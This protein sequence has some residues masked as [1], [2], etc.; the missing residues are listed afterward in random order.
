MGHHIYIYVDIDSICINMHQWIEQ[1]ITT[2]NHL[3]PMCEHQSALVSIIEIAVLV[4]AVEKT[5]ED[6]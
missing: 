5:V 3:E 4:C 6:G 2:W 1:T